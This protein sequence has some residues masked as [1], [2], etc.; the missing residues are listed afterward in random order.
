M[1]Q[2]RHNEFSDVLNLL[3]RER[4][5]DDVLVAA[6]FRRHGGTVT[7]M[8]V[9]NW[10]EGRHHPRAHQYRILSQIFGVSLDY[11]MRGVEREPAQ[12]SGDDG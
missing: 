11:L 9:R 10:R 4:G 2:Q 6:E 7:P 3:M 8:S 5:L 1:N 12:C